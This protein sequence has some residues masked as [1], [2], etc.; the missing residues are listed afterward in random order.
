MLLAQI[1][2]AI[3]D[4]LDWSYAVIVALIFRLKS[5]TRLLDI[6]LIFNQ[7]IRPGT[8]QQKLGMQTAYY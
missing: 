2:A 5:L 8:Y 1:Y 6:S 7:N 4:D 3:S